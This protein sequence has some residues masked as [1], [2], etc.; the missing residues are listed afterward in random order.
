[1]ATVLQEKQKANLS[2]SFFHLVAWKP[3]FAF[4]K[5]QRVSKALGYFGGSAFHLPPI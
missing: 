5:L 2:V 3:A 4:P 1:M